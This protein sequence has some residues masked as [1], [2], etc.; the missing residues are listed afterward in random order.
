MT[1]HIKLE[2]PNFNI[3]NFNMPNFKIPITITPFNFWVL[4]STLFTTTGGIVSLYGTD[5]TGTCRLGVEITAVALQ[6][7]AVIF[8][9]IAIAIAGWNTHSNE[10]I[11]KSYAPNQK[12]L[13]WHWKPKKPRNREIIQALILIIANIACLI[14]AI[15]IL[16]DR[17]CTVFVYNAVYNIFGGGRL[18]FNHYDI[19]SRSRIE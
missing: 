12:F 9:L 4:L 14:M 17:Q 18:I 13:G 2:M 16:V 15:L 7:V 6:G 10:N 11:K 5:P 8:C 19:I 1:D 3:L